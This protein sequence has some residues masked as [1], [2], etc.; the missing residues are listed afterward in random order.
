MSISELYQA[1]EK[2]E[3]EKVNISREQTIL[4]NK[5][6]NIW[7]TNH[8]IGEVVH[9]IS[10]MAVVVSKAYVSDHTAR[11]FLASL[12]DSPHREPKVFIGSIDGLLLKSGGLK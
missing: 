11:L 12:H 2:L 4:L 8:K 3:I 5:I 6:V 9:H 7:N 10:G 1:H